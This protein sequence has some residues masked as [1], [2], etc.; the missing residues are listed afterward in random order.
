MALIKANMS[1]R[2]DG[3][4]QL[5]FR[6]NAECDEATDLIRKTEGLPYSPFGGGLAVERGVIFDSSVTYEDITSKLHDKLA[7]E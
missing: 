4:Y 5:K 7:L 6:T 3:R 1:R 2:E